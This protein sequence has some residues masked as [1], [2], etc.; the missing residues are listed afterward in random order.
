MSVVAG[1]SLYLL[2]DNVEISIKQMLL[3]VVV[4]TAAARQLSRGRCVELNKADRRTKNVRKKEC[5]Y[6]C[7]KFSHRYQPHKACKHSE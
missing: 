6:S 4:N 3:S 7:G 5:F 2:M 1:I